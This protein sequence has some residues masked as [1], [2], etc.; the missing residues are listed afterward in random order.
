MTNGRK[1]RKGRFWFDMA[2]RTAENCQ[3][4]SGAALSPDAFRQGRSDLFKVWSD[5]W[6]HFLR[7]TSFL[8]AE[9]QCLSGSLEYRKQ[10]REYL[11]RLHHELQLPSSQIQAV[12][13]RR[14]K[15]YRI[16]EKPLDERAS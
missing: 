3:S 5:Y 7:S 13:G 14:Y 8:D 11:E 1:P 16:Y 4:W 6:E 12:G 2:S 9:K 15:T 10:F